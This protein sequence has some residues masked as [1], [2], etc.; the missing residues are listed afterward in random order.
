[1]RVSWLCYG[2]ICLVGE[3]GFRGAVAHAGGD[4]AS[5]VLGFSTTSRNG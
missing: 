3:G 4:D 2:G 1:M 5:L